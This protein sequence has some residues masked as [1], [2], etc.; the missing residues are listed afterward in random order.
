MGIGSIISAGIGGLLG[1][2][3]ARSAA[4]LS[5]K[6]AREQMAFTERMSNTAYQRSA[7]DLEAAGLNRILALGSPASTPGGAMGAVPDFGQAMV[8]GAQAA[9]GLRTSAGQRTLMRAQGLNQVSTARAADAQAR[10]HDSTVGVNAARAREINARATL[11]EKAAGLA[12]QSEAGWQG[13]KGLLDALVPRAAEATNSA[14]TWVQ[15]SLEEAQRLRDTRRRDAEGFRI[16]G[17][18]KYMDPSDP[19]FLRRWDQ[20]IKRSQQ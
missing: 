19:E 12:D 13:L 10:V 9:D 11:A 3:G 2:S 16:Y 20:K 4:R 5:Q 7:A 14:K 1:I 18:D 6:Q 8:S 17:K 15:D